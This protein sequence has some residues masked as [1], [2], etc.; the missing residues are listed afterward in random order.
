M[1]SEAINSKRYV[2]VFSSPGLNKRHQRF[3]EGAAKNK[4]IYLTEAFN[5]SRMIE[6][7]WRN[8]PAIYTT[9]DNLLVKEAIKKIL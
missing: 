9:G 1:V 2:L 8:K 7:V 3:L 6:Q 4:Y 5:L